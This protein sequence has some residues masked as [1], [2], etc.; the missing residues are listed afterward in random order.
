MR[1]ED[2]IQSKKT[3]FT[4]QDLL[5][6]FPTNQ[7]QTV[8]NALQRMKKKWLVQNIIPGIRWL[9]TYHPYELACKLKKNSYISLQTVLK[10]AWVLFQYQGQTITAISDNTLT[11]H[12]WGY[13]YQYRKTHD[14]IRLD[15]EWIIHTQT[16][17][18]ATLERAL[19]D[20]IYL[21]PAMTFDD[22]SS[23]DIRALKEIALLYPPFVLSR[24]EALLHDW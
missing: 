9:M 10:E 17:A 23:L 12:A 1:Y 13:V 2:L 7:A 8:R 6:I 22:Y 14:N 18:I 19:C 21:S 16:Y 11:K 15:P 4:I 5:V 3:V 20:M 24:I